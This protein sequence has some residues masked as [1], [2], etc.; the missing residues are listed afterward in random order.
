RQNFVGFLS[1]IKTQKRTANLR[2]RVNLGLDSRAIS[3]PVA[4]HNLL[5]SILGQGPEQD[6]AIVS[7]GPRGL[8]DQPQEIQNFPHPR[9]RAPGSPK[10]LPRCLLYELTFHGVR[11]HDGK[12]S[13]GRARTSLK[14]PSRILISLI[15][16]I[17]P[18]RFARERISVCARSSSFHCLPRVPGWRR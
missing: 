15:L 3:L 17:C 9:A 6:R 10:R 4:H 7:I 8:V 14:A 5:I 11:G 2:P 13:W 12:R 16:E 18:I 1:A